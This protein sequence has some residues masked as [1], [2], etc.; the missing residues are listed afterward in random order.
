MSKKAG[1]LSKIE[2]DLTSLNKEQSFNSK[3]GKLGKDSA[4]SGLAIAALLFATHFSL[5]ALHDPEEYNAVKAQIKA[6]TFTVP[7][8]HYADLQEVCIR[9]ALGDDE[10]LDLKDMS[11]D[12]ILSLKD[13][14]N[15]Q[16]GERCSDEK[17]SRYSQYNYLQTL[18]AP[19]WPLNAGLVFLA[20]SAFYLV[21]TGYSANRRRKTQ[22]NID[23]KSRDLDLLS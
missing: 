3:I 4:M 6:Q 16:L 1:I 19:S 10:G 20:S 5:A 2:N 23:K 17:Y 21:V 8:A 18:D 12:D 14:Y 15:D 22:K 13:T 11:Q 7:A 9:S